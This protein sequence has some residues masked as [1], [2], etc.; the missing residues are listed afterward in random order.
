M[1][2]SLEISRCCLQIFIDIYLKV[3]IL[4]Q[5]INNY[6]QKNTS[7][8]FKY[9]NYNC[10]SF[11]T[12]FYRRSFKFAI[13]T[14]QKDRQPFTALSIYASLATVTE[15]Y[16]KAESLNCKN[17]TRLQRPVCEKTRQLILRR[18]LDSLVQCFQLRL[19]NFGYF[20]ATVAELVNISQGCKAV[21]VEK[22]TLA[23]SCSVNSQ[24]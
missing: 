23:F 16:P 22:N 7:L 20:T 18:R 14:I 15:N 17:L 10:T 2:V 12:Y 11:Q 19:S 9:I 5:N 1:Q 6:Q 24:F 3:S 4:F 8:E 21:F 13:D